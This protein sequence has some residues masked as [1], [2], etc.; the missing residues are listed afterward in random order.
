[1]NL[2][3]PT[4]LCCLHDTRLEPTHDAM[5]LLP[6]DGMPLHLFVGGCT[7]RQLNGC[8]LGGLFLLCRHLPCLLSRLANLSRAERPDGSLPTFVGGDVAAQLNPYPLHYRA[9]FACSIFMSPLPP[10]RPLRSAVPQGR[11]M[12]LPRSA[13]VP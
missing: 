10:G 3:P 13:S 8:R 11:A 2:A 9:A 7:S 5:S 1:M 6:L 4:F 12:G